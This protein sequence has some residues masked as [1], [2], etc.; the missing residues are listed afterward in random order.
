MLFRSEGLEDEGTSNNEIETSR[1]RSPPQSNVEVTHK[2]LP[3][4]HPEIF[5]QRLVSQPDNALD[6]VLRSPIPL[7]AIQGGLPH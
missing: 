4:V 6:D 5:Q 7:N 2:K 3:E 1:Q